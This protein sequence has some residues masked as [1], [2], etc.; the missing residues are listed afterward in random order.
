[1]TTNYEKTKQWLK[2]LYNNLERTVRNFKLEDYADTAFRIQLATEQLQKAL[3]DFLGIQFRR[4]HEPSRII[5]SII[6]EKQ[7]SNI[8]L[9]E[10]ILE[11]LKEISFF[12]KKLEKE[13]SFTRYGV[14][15][16]D[17]LITPTEYYSKEKVLKFLTYIC[18]IIRII[19]DFFEKILE[20][21][22][23]VI[24]LKEYLNQIIE[25]IKNDKESRT[26]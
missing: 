20:L 26:N 5:D 3:L 2:L 19:I 4:T 11:K 7:Y 13:K 10:P 6:Y 23:E 12:A 22:R 1:M 17:E 24:I 16:E 9:E 21:N 25:L 8:K 14:I 15:K 18:K